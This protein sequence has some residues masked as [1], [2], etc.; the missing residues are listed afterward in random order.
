MKVKR[1]PCNKYNYDSGHF[2]RLKSIDTIYIHYTANDNDSAENNG[3]YFQKAHEPPTSAHYFIDRNGFIIKSVKYRYIAYAVGNWS[4]NC[5]SISIE[6]CDFNNNKEISEAQKEALIWLIKY[7]KKKIP[8]IKYFKR[9]YDASG[10][11]CPINLIDLK[12]WYQF[13]NSLH[14]DW[15]T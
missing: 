3:L 7:L 4:E 8:T 11:K 6:L 12:K 1:I 14:I 13:K 9:H 15:I 10:K 2:R 5:R